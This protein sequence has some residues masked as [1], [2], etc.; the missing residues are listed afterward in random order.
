MIDGLQRMDVDSA[1]DG[2]LRA[3][4][5]RRKAELTPIVPALVVAEPARRHAV[6]ASPPA[7]SLTLERARQRLRETTVLDR[8]VFS[9]GLFV[10]G[11]NSSSR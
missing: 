10:P 11:K 4:V 5:R 1:R 3:Q 2:I 9:L 7:I 6:T 8:D